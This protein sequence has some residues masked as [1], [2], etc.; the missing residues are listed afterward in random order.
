MSQGCPNTS[1]FSRSVSTQIRFL[2]IVGFHFFQIFAPI[3]STSWIWRIAPPVRVAIQHHGTRNAPSLL[4]WP[5]PPGGSPDRPGGPPPCLH[6]PLPR[7]VTVA[8]EA[9]AG[10]A[11]PPT[12]VITRTHSTVL[13][14][15]SGYPIQPPWPTRSWNTA[16]AAYCTKWIL[17][18]HTG[19]F[20]PTRW[21]G[22]SA[23]LNGTNSFSWISPSL[24]DYV[25]ELLLAKGPQKLF[26][27]SPERRQELIPPPTLTT[28]SGLPYHRQ[29]GRITTTFWTSWLSWVWRWPPRNAKVPPPSSPGSEWSST[30]SSSPWP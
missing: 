13:H 20:G 24:S 14:S 12:N 30:H 9:E 29:L 17:A 7:E 19:S 28:P 22:L 27:P 6:H 26:P 1:R 15:S 8:V 3:A 4:I 5:Q 23:C 10:V 25:T 11:G 2:T 18:E 21:I 16:G